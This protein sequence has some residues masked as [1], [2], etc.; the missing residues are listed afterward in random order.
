MEGFKINKNINENEK[1]DFE[2]K[3]NNL[4]EEESNFEIEDNIENNKMLEEKDKLLQELK[5]KLEKEKNENYKMKLECIK[6]KKIQEENILNKDSKKI[7][8][9]LEKSEIKE[10]WFKFAKNDINENFVDFNPIQTFHLI[11][12]LFILCSNLLQEL[13]KEKYSEILNALHIPNTDYQMK[14]ISKDLK[15]IILGNIEKVI[16]IEEENEKFVKNFKKEYKE[17]CLK[18]IKNKNEEFNDFINEKSFKSMLDGVKNIILF[19]MFNEPNLHFEIEE[20]PSKRIIEEIIIKNNREKYIIVNDPGLNEFSS[21]LL[22]NPPVTSS[23]NEISDLSDLKK[24]IIKY[25]RNETIDDDFSKSESENINYDSK[26]SND[27][28]LKPSPQS[29]TEIIKCNN[30][31]DEIPIKYETNTGSKLEMIKYQKKKKENDILCNKSTLLYNVFTNPVSSR[32]EN[33]KKNKYCNLKE[34]SGEHEH[35]QTDTKELTSENTYFDIPSEFNNTQNYKKNLNNDKLLSNN[36]NLTF[37]NKNNPYQLYNKRIFTKKKSTLNPNIKREKLICVKRGSSNNPKKFI[38]KRPKEMNN[39]NPGT[40]RITTKKILNSENDKMDYGCETVLSSP[41]KDINSIKKLRE[42]NLNELKNYR[43]DSENS[44]NK[45]TECHI[46]NVNINLININQTNRVINGNKNK[47]DNNNVDNYI[48][49]QIFDS[50]Q[51]DE[52]SNYVK[53]GLSKNKTLIIKVKKIKNCP[54]QKEIMVSTN[55]GQT[56][57]EILTDGSN[58]YQLNTPNSINNLCNI[59]NKTSLLKL[60]KGKV[61]N[62]I[63]MDSP[64]SN[65]NYFHNK[66]INSN[67]FIGNSDNAFRKKLSNN[68]NVYMK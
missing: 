49:P 52:V 46:Q 38:T 9:F 19:G 7:K 6:L 61:D 18:Y 65:K 42:K 41:G 22:L 10:K 11:S 24:I 34:F 58:H 28:I 47:K 29:S 30:D 39:F 53:A 23:L 67:N 40:T 17:K 62:N 20:D 1:E 33:K 25:D 60:K 5:E 68:N 26:D 48:P 27:I 66:N 21:I 12:E 43:N 14:N 15:N 50:N 4:Q 32:L 57:D 54:N 63:R 45:K 56:E 31:I 3:Y 44:I 55:I 37:K 64:S 13:L 8:N 36:K 35:L 59:K 2:I 51:I 16:F